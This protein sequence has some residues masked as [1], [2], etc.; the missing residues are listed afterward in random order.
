MTREEILESIKNKTPV[1]VTVVKG[2]K[3]EMLFN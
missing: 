1:I 2:G 3:Y